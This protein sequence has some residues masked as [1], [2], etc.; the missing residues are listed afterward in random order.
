M[1][2]QNMGVGGSRTR[3]KPSEVPL[4]FG[5]AENRE[6]F[7]ALLQEMKLRAGVTGA[8]LA[9]KMGVTPN[10][11]H[12]YFYKKRG[13]GGTSTMRWFVRFAEACGCEVVVTF[14]PPKTGQDRARIVGGNRPPAVSPSYVWSQRKSWETDAKT[15]K[16]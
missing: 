15:D 11:V 1:K 13:A 3:G 6:G 4:T 9:A 12:Q 14:P 8:E 7:A 2:I 10:A 5:V 16:G